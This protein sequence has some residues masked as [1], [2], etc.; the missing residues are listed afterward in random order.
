MIEILT[1]ELFQDED[2]RCSSRTRISPLH[3]TT[4]SSQ[5]RTNAGFK[6]DAERPESDQTWRK[7]EHRPEETLCNRTLCREDRRKTNAVSN[8]KTASAPTEYYLKDPFTFKSVK[9]TGDGAF[10]VSLTAEMFCLLGC[11]SMIGR[12]RQN[13][14]MSRSRVVGGL[15]E[16]KWGRRKEWGEEG[17]KI[18]AKMDGE[19]KDW[20]NGRGEARKSLLTAQRFSE[21]CIFQRK[22]LLSNL[23]SVTR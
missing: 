17:N 19:I 12:K 5:N 13:C 2:S 1:P 10:S 18:E 3:K 9:V 15:K 16:R 20:M 21:R 14:R 22:W 6:Q 11:E 4:I 7:P 23:A 8:T